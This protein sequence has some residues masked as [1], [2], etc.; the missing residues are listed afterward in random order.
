[1]I[2]TPR[3]RALFVL[4]LIATAAAFLLPQLWLFSLSLKIES[5]DVRVSADVGA[6]KWFGW[7]T[8]GSC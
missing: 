3:R 8:T 6:E 5:R 2:A 4:G 1:M 7:R